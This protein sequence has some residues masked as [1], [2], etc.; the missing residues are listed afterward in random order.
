[1]TSPSAPV[2]SPLE[3]ERDPYRVVVVVLAGAAAAGAG[4]ALAQARRSAAPGREPE[5]ND[6]SHEREVD[7]DL[8]TAGAPVSTHER[9]AR[10]DVSGIAS[11]IR[12]WRPAG[13]AAHKVRRGI[14]W[15]SLLGVIAIRWVGA[16]S[17][18][19]PT[20]LVAAVVAIS[21]GA[22]A[23]LAATAV[24][25]LA[26]IDPGALPGG[27]ALARG[28]RVAAWLLVLAGASVGL[29]WAEWPVP[30]SVI[31]AVIIVGLKVAF[32]VAAAM[33]HATLWMAVL[34]GDT[35]R[36]HQH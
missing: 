25:Y 8:E 26:E 12:R 20:A 17:T 31:N 18:D 23:G 24:R 21:C 3:S 19:P 16:A 33:G 32:L 4:V 6:D 10:L 13:G 27:A 34:A 1:M 36:A 15:L 14:A 7:A 30:L 22:A 2:E 11:A 28:G 5:A 9:R 35:H 29:Q